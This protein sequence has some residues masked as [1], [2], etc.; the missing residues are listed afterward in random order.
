MIAARIPPGSAER[1]ICLLR[2]TLATGDENP[3]FVPVGIDRARDLIALNRRGG[4][5]VASPKL[6]AL[7]DPSGAPLQSDINREFV[8]RNAAADLREPELAFNIS[9]DA[10][11][12]RFETY[13]AAR[14]PPPPTTFNLG[15]V[16]QAASADDALATEAP[17]QDPN[18]VETGATAALRASSGSRCPVAR[19]RKDEMF[20]AA[21]VL[22]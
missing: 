19:S 20:R 6:I 22:L 15:K 18:I 4:I 9:P 11:V 17:N 3:E 8:Q 21:A 1:D 5:L 12:V 10:Q 16:P 13:E 2:W 7:L 14:Q